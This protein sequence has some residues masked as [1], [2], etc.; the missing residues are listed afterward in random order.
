MPLDV[1][2]TVYQSAQNL[3]GDR[4]ERYGRRGPVACAGAMLQDSGPK[5]FMRGW[6]P[7]FMRMAPTCVSSFWLYEQLRRLVGIG[8]LD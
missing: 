4:L 5:V 3:G 7:A 1:V 8:Y 6:V 2:L